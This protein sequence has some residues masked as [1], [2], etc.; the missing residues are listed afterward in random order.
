MEGGVFC[1]MCSAPADLTTS[2]IRKGLCLWLA[3]LLL[4]VT[5]LEADTLALPRSILHRAGL[6]AAAPPRVSAAL[7]GGAAPPSPAGVADARGCPAGSLR[8]ARLFASGLVLQ[9]GVPARVWGWAHETCEVRATLTVGGGP[10]ARVPVEHRGGGLWVATVPLQAAGGGGGR[11]AFSTPAGDAALIDG[12]AW[13]EVLLCLGQSNMQS[14]W[15]GGQVSAALDVERERGGAP[16]AG[17]AA[18]LPVRYFGVGNV[19]VADVSVFVGEPLED[20]PVAPQAAWVDAAALTHPANVVANLSAVCWF[21]GRALAAA[22]G[23]RVP[24]GLV[25]A[26]VGGSYLVHWAGAPA[27][28]ACDAPE[29]AAD[30]RFGFPARGHPLWNALLAPLGVGPLAVAGG[31]W[32]QGESEALAGQAAWYECG[33]PKFFGALRALLGMPRLW[34]G[35]VQ[36]APF[37]ADESQLESIPALRVAQARV[38]AALPHAD[39]ISAVDAGEP[40]SPVNNLHPRFKRVI[41]ERLGAAAA[42]ALRGEPPPRHPTFAGA[43]ADGGAA[44]GGC[45]LHVTVAVDAG[46]A[47]GGG[48]LTWLPWAEAS[49]SSRCPL[50]GFERFCGGFEVQDAAGTWHNASAALLPGGAPRL[51][52]VVAPRAGVRC[53]EPGA[54]VPPATATRNGWAPWPVVNVAAGGLPLLPWP[55]TPLLPALP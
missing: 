53:G 52:L 17:A 24:V 34:L 46:G 18:P 5:F 45:S 26:A 31:A 30:R 6:F 39:L 8:L 41:G 15:P 35:V 28:V 13:G 38:A 14:F 25:E 48:V 7:P 47:P 22:L 16:D 23:G 37:Y 55:P 9:H 44:D 20:F 36:L 12:V 43:A 3:L 27:T 49:F 50:I 21:A 42:A 40:F 1:A 51:R 19:P 4:T 2:V 10:P 11:L 29:V 32:Y 33:L 54:P